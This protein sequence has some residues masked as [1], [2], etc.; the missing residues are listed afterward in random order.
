MIETENSTGM[1]I[2]KFNL[3]RVITY[4]GR[5]LGSYLGLEH[6]EGVSLASFLGFLLPLVVTHRA[7]TMIAQ[8]GKRVSAGMSIG[9]ANLNSFPRAHMDLQASRLLAYIEW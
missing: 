6:R 5:R 8:I 9:P 7:G 2:G 4:R 1:A 3:N